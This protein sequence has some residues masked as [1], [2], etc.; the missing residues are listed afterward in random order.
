MSGGQLF[1]DGVDI[2]QA[3]RA[4]LRSQLAFIP[5]TPDLF[6]G[7]LRDNLDPLG[8]YEEADLRDVLRDARLGALSLDTQVEHGGANFSVGERQLLSL[9]R[10]MLTPACCLV[11]DEAVRRAEDTG[12]GG[13]AE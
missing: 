10:A 5:Q 6:T 3:T 2:T 12:D 11:M 13:G 7:S 1:F 4:S 8:V 9:A